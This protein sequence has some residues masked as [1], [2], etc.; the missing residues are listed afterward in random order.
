MIDVKPQISESGWRGFGGKVQMRFKADFRTLKLFCGQQELPP[1]H[2]GRIE[3][4]V[5]IDNATTK[6]FDTTSEGLYVFGP[7]SIGPQCGQVR[8]EVIDA[9][10]PEKGETITV[11]PAMVSRV[12][13]DFAAYRA[14]AR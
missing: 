1:I 5:A 8:L 7:E 10:H 6:M 14:A 9:A 12:W 2:P 11:P 4:V 13:N 3:H